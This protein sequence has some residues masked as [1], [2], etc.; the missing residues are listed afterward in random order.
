MFS[1]GTWTRFRLVSFLPTA[2]SCV[3]SDR[4]GA[5]RGA[6][7]AAPNAI[8]ANGRIAAP[9]AIPS[10]QIQPAQFQPR[11]MEGYPAWIIDRLK[12]RDQKILDDLGDK[13]GSGAVPSALIVL[14]TAEWSPGSTITVAF[15]GGTPRLH[16]LLERIVSEWS[17]FANIKF[18]F[19]RDASG[20]YRT[21]SPSDL[22]YKAD[23]RVAFNGDGYWSVVGKNTINPD[24]YQPGTQTMNLQGFD[25]SLPYGF[26]GVAR[27]EFGHVLGLEHEHQSPVVT[28]GFRWADDPGYVPTT[29]QSGAFTHDAQNR[30]PGIYT[31]MEGPPNK[32]SKQQV[33]YNLL[34]LSKV[35]N[36]PV[37]DYSIGPFDKL[38]IMK[39]YYPDRMFVSGKNSQC[40]SPNENYDLSAEDKQLIAASYPKDATAAAALLEKKRQAIESV[41]SQVP[42]SSLLAKGLQLKQQKLQ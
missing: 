37:T 36:I 8:K 41:L 28:C 31:Y 22:D 40:Y 10:G 20:H 27:H 26:E 16:A 4:A 3:S 1:L 11:I 42:Q 14:R 17:E 23:V 2:E 5:D 24:L 19:G 18:D 29:D 6:K 25:S 21:W 32:W 9:A 7:I 15:N 35:D 12:L 33:D 13:L 34:P 30:F 38:S 39:Y